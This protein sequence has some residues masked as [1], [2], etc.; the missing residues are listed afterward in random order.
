MLS[1]AAVVVMM[2]ESEALA[3]AEPPPATL[4]VFT[5]GEAAVAATLALTVIA[6]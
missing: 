1:A 2:V 3:L 5:T 6:G 4:A